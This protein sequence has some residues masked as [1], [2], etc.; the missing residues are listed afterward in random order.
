MK[1]MTSQ[2]LNLMFNPDEHVCISPD[3]YGY[4]SI[5]QN[6]I[7]D[8]IYLVSPNP[9]VETKKISENDIISVAINP[10]KG[11][12]QDRFVTAYR[13]FMVELDTGGLHQQSQYID[14]L[15]MPYSA[16]IFSGNKSLHYAIVLGYG[17]PKSAWKHTAQW[18]LNVVTQADQQVKNP[19]RAI[20]FP[21]NQRPGGKIQS[22][23]KMKERVE[24]EDLF[25]W[26]N[27]FPDAKP[28]PVRKKVGRRNTDSVRRIPKRV[29]DTLNDGIDI[30]RNSTWFSLACSMISIGYDLDDT[31]GYFE[32]H[33][34]EDAD[35]Q[36][37][38]WETCINSAYKHMQG[39]L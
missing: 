23:V 26:L 3:K 19:S 29:I 14:S 18:I 37:K 2:F 12:R 22:L 38:E 33:F 25:A 6:T 17:L 21:G 32:N 34:E 28:K 36:R 20:R 11:F 27:K 39:V 1:K 16:C 8:D 30:D 35:F 31:M 5:E 7:G 13:S 24:T 9:D 4:H 15:G 10:I